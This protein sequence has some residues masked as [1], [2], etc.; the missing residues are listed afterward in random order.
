MANTAS[1]SR[2]LY[3]PRELVFDAWTQGE[4]LAQWYA[5]D[6]CLAD[7]VVEPVAG[8]RFEV[9]WSDPSGGRFREAGTFAEVSPPEGFVC[10]LARSRADA[11]VEQTRLSLELADLVDACRI[12]L[13]EEAAAGGETSDARL[14]EFRQRWESRLDRLE[15]YFSAI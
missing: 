6:D 4:H 13:R 8:G 5:P 11:D 1:M 15:G 3:L 2:E 14:E 7:A 12:T 10:T 9:A